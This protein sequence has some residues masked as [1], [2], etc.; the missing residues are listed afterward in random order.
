M[1]GRLGDVLQTAAGPVAPVKIE[2]IVENL[3]GVA[4]AALVGVG[5]EGL[6]Q[7]VVIVQLDSPP[8]KPR[9]ANLAFIDTVRDAVW[10]ATELD[11]VAVLSVPALPV[12]RRHNSKIDHGRLR[13]WAT[14]AL[15]GGSIGSI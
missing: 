8:K 14:K 13:E 6:E 3:D 12:D 5:P 1:G 11:V 10:K 15:N 2:Q 7:P 4:M 9:M